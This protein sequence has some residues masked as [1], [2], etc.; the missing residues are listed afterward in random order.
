MRIQEQQTDET[1]RIENKR[2]GNPQSKNED[3]Y[4]LCRISRGTISNNILFIRNLVNH[5]YFLLLFYD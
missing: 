5:R 2:E 3:N 1:L 4:Y